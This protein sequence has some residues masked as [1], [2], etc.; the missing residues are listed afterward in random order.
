M[1][2]LCSCGKNIHDFVIVPHSP[3]VYSHAK[4]Q[5]YVSLSHKQDTWDYA[6]QPTEPKL[7][8]ERCNLQLMLRLDLLT[9]ELEE[10][11]LA[12][13]AYNT[14]LYDRL[15][16]GFNSTHMCGSDSE[17]EALFE[18]L[19]NLHKSCDQ[20]KSKLKL[21]CQEDLQNQVNDEGVHWEQLNKLNKQLQVT[22]QYEG[23]LS[24]K[25]EELVMEIGYNSGPTS[26]KVYS[27]AFQISA[28]QGIG[29]I[30]SLRLGRLPD[31][32]VDW[33]EINSAWGQTALLLYTL[34]KKLSFSF[35]K[36]KVIPMG[37]RPTIQ[38]KSAPALYPLYGSGNIT[39]GRSF[40]WTTSSSAD[41]D[42]GMEAFLF[43]VSELCARVLSVSP[44]IA[45]PY[46]IDKDKIGARQDG[47]KSV[48]IANNSE[49]DW[50]KALKYMLTNLKRILISLP[51]LVEENLDF[52]GKSKNWSPLAP[53]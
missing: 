28:V 48:R 33:D 9:S 40:F 37:S 15:A 35:T 17:E 45:L 50:S 30:N 24:S 3:D 36:Y 29:T 47:L 8:C 12:Y 6:C 51:S 44:A 39:F 13:L 52:M 18:E 16:T 1:A 31:V 11:L 46:Y 14:E 25:A 43:C 38:H 2:A 53:M 41:F 26:N 4:A 22:S 27:D 20:V 5:K 10:D 32:L 49:V 23:L 7:F 42:I 19:V 34:A 21:I